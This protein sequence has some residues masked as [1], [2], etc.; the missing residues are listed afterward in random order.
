VQLIES[1][2]SIF[3]NDKLTNEV[4][5]YQ[6]TTTA[7]MYNQIFPTFG[8]WKY[9]QAF[10]INDMVN[11][12]VNKI[13]KTA[14]ALPIYA[15]Q[16]DGQDLSDKDRL[17]IFLS[18]LTY[19][20]KLELY[21]W[22]ALADEVVIYKDRPLIGVNGYVEKIYFLNPAYVTI[23]VSISFP[24]EILGYIY[25]DPNNNIEKSIDKE[26]CI[27][28]HG[29][30]PTLDMYQKWR[31][32][33]KTEVLRQRL[34]RME[35]NMRNSVGQMQNGG[36]PGVLFAK[37]LPNTSQSK[38]VVDQMKQNF[39]RFVSNPDNKGN[40]FIQAGE[41]GYV[42]IGSTLVDLDSLDL[43]KADNKAVCSVWGVSDVLFNSDSAATESNVKEM[44][45]QMYTN[46]VMPYTRMVDD[47]F[48]NELSTDFG[49]G[50][51]VIKTDFSDVPELQTSMKEK[52]DSLAAAPTMIPNDVLQ[53][54]GYDR[55]TDPLMDEP[56]IKSG[57][58]PVSDF[59]PV[60]P[61]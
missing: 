18:K 8:T 39:S 40:P 36:T 35:S 50:F 7:Q 4:K 37:E 51:K 27:F 29:F 17:T 14:A 24:Q 53:A 20:E 47:A 61:V 59:N 5:A 32:L 46:A 3:R 38:T 45:R 58:Q 15:F 55:S 1:I 56:Y 23:V 33:P 19:V 12:V 21:T 52:I 25:R 42:Q 6:T 34:T 26:E 48:N 60:E 41:M 57:Y 2:K 44:I 11:A 16:G 30:N 13:A 9:I 22:L 10:H 43:E 31:G 49:T 54:L 28:I